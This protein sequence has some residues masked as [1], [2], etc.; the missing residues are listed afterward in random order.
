MAGLGDGFSVTSI[1]GTPTRPLLREFREGLCHCRRGASRNELGENENPDSIYTK[2][3]NGTHTWLDR[4]W[5]GLYL[6]SPA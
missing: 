3:R 5:L 2:H 4:Q 6:T 1:A